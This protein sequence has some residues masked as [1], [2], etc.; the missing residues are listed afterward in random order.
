MKVYA[1]IAMIAFAHLTNMKDKQPLMTPGDHFPVH[2]NLNEL[3][4]YKLT[5]GAKQLSILPGFL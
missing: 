4:L 3:G 1:V 5:V 2:L